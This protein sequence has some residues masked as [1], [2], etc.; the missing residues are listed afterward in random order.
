[1]VK[2]KSQKSKEKKR[3]KEHIK[4]TKKKFKRKKILNLKKSFQKKIVEHIAISSELDTVS[5][6][7]EF[8]LS[9]ALPGSILR[10]AQTPQ[11][12]AYLAGQV[13]RACAV[14]QVRTISFN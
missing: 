14:F 12:R 7:R 10:N 1:M 5:K 6:G 11:L 8:T 2:D 13:A 4:D 3:K 9:I